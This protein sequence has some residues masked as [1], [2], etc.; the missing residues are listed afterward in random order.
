MKFDA[1]LDETL[2]WLPPRQRETVTLACP[3]P[4]WS[5]YLLSEILK[6]KAEPAPIVPK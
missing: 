2:S 1:L 5:A 3:L 6:P 4:A